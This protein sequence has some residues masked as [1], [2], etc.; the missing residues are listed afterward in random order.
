MLGNLT[1]INESYKLEESL[2]VE[3]IDIWQMIKLSK[4]YNL[5][6]QVNIKDD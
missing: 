2:S 4:A 3:R 6:L 5:K 1:L